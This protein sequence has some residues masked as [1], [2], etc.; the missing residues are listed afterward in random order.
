[1]LRL[2]VAEVARAQGISQVRL[3]D[4]SGLSRTTIQRY[5][6]NHVRRITFTSLDAIAQALNV[7]FTD[8]F[9]GDETQQGALEQRE[10][11]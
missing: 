6:Q 9:L 5:W 2:K 7:S 3:Q 11:S 10:P 4:A 8:L 1:M